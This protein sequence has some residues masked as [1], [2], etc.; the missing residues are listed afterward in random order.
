M[1]YAKV[2]S[3]RQRRKES[4][5]K[6]LSLPLRCRGSAV[7]FARLTCL[8]RSLIS[9]GLATFSKPTG[10]S[11]IPPDYRQGTSFSLSSSRCRASQLTVPWWARAIEAPYLNSAP[12]LQRPEALFGCQVPASPSSPSEQSFPPPSRSS[13]QSLLPYFSF[14]LLRSLR[15]FVVISLFSSLSLTSFAEMHI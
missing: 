12:N 1:R 5:N 10:N 2:E 15:P 8:C 7:S 6:S 11:V 14:H 3:D 4:N 13:F 9:A